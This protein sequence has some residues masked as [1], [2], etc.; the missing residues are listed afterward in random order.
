MATSPSAKAPHGH[1]PATIDDAR[2]PDAAH[3]QRQLV[4]DAA[5]TGTL[6]VAT[7]W[8]GGGALLSG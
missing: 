5:Y 8:A 3:A 1:H 4:L 6:I 2:A 7:A